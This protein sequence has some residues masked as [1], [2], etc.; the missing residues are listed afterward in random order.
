MALTLIKET[1]AGLSDANSYASAAD[2]NAY[3]DGHLYAASWTAV[4]TG[5]KKRRW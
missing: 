3:H 5:S 2:G 4:V 1:G